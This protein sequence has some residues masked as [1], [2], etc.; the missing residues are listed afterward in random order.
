MIAV[1]CVY[2]VQSR[3][4]TLPIPDTMSGKSFTLSIRDTFMQ[5][6]SGNQTITSG[7]N[8]AT[9]WGPTLFMNKGDTVRMTVINKLN[10]STTVHWHG[11]HLPAV[12]DGGPHQI[13][14]PGTVWQPYLE[15]DKPGSDAMVPSPFTRDDAGANDQ[16][17]R[18]IY[19]YSRRTGISAKA[20]AHLRCG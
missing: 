14:P 2:G 12:M 20:A 19:Y 13:I 8:G 11:M 7:V 4:T 16:R 5:L 1:M 15:G 18:R 3:A 6:R 10:D 9:F 17:R